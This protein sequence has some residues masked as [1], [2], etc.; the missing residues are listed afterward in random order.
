MHIAAVLSHA[1]WPGISCHQL[2]QEDVLATPIEVVEGTALIPD[3]PGLGV[4]INEDAMERLRLSGP[5][6]GFNPPR[7]IEVSWPTGERYYYSSG[8]QLWR[9][10]QAGNMPVFIEGVKTRVAPNDG[11]A[12]WRDLHERASEKPVRLT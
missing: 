4:E 9:D 2:Y 3:A 1:N 8:R 10:A 12:H 11:S 6:E 5:Y 7:L